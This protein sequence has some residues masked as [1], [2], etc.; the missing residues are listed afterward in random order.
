MTRATFSAWSSWPVSQFAGVAHVPSPLAFWKLAVQFSTDDSPS[1]RAVRECDGRPTAPIAMQATMRFERAERT[2]AARRGRV[3]VGKWFMRRSC[4]ICEMRVAECS[5][6]VHT[7]FALS[8]QPCSG[9]RGGI[10]KRAHSDS[11]G[12]VPGQAA[13]LVDDDMRAL[14]NGPTSVICATADRMNTPDVTRVAGLGVREG[15]FGPSSSHRGSARLKR[16]TRPR[17]PRTQRSSEA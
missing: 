4:G 5:S 12:A 8:K 7:H 9:E 3:L 10:S 6:P 14:I 16:D 1:A 17:Q 15:T 13:D 11:F 2:R